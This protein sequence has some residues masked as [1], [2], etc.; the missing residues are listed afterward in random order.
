MQK[1]FNEKGYSLQQMVLEQLDIYSQKNRPWPK[2]HT[3]YKINIKGV[4]DLNV[5]LWKLCKKT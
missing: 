3:L 2:T 1:Q 4:I 5:K